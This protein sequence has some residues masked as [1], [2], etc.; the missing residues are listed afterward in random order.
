MR[1][2]PGAW[3]GVFLLA[4]VICVSCSTDSSAPFEPDVRIALGSDAPG[5][6]VGQFICWNVGRLIRYAGEGDPFHP[7]WRT[8][9]MV[10]VANWLSQIQPGNGRPV[11]M[12]Y[13]GL[14]IDGSVATRGGTYPEDGY[15]FWRYVDPS[16]EVEPGDYM[17]VPQYMAFIEESG[18]VPLVTLNFGSG[19]ASEAA[20]YVR[21]LNATDPGPSLA[22]ARAFWGRG[23][24][25]DVHLFEIG[26]ESYFSF[27]TGYSQDHAYAYANPKAPNGGDPL[28]HGKPTSDPANYAERAMEYIRAVQ[29]VEPDAR[30]LT[31]F[32][33]ASLQ[34][35]GGL[36]AT[37]RALQPLLTHSSVAGAVVHQY[38]LDDA[39]TVGVPGVRRPDFLM[40]SADVFEENYG[41]LASK[42]ASLPRENPDL[43]IA[44]T[45]HHATA[46]G[47]DLGFFDARDDILPALAVADNLLLF[48]RLGVEPAC[49]HMDIRFESTIEPWFNPFSLEADG[50]VRPKPLYEAV[51]LVAE[52]LRQ[53]V[54]GG[55]TTSGEPPELSWV[56]MKDGAS[57]EMS[58]LLLNRGAENSLAVS[59]EVG[60]GWALHSATTLAGPPSGASDRQEN[61]VLRSLDARLDGSVLEVELPIGSLSGIVLRAKGRGIAR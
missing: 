20:E 5:R 46:L 32:N 25:Y 57:E 27:N 29:T 35:W 17:S 55:G 18:G 23:E 26:N 16:R 52:Y 24:P 45:E 40:G 7:E 41:A 56:A 54:V 28:W 21:F 14:M 58:F 1:T 6:P 8:P 9:E 3:S 42:L 36:E 15:H 51:R 22:A 34:Y 48:L 11:L 43:R 49:V 38:N 61:M 44:V 59:V 19:T 50:S 30:F 53:D 4:G 37:T 60:E 33:Q 47:A 10:S 13:S 12:R 31:V 39:L 2:S